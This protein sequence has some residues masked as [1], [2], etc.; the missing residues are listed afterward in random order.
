MKN[1]FKWAFSKEFRR[2]Q[3]PLEHSVPVDVG[4]AFITIRYVHT[5]D[6]N[7]KSIKDFSF[8]MNGVKTVSGHVHARAKFRELLRTL[9]APHGFIRHIGLDEPVA[10]ECDSEL[11]IKSEDLIDISAKYSHYTI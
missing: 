8:I 5:S 1:L 9:S 4:S 11:W 2:D 7:E 3:A 10:V 6:A